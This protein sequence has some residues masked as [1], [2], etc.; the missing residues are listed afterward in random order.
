MKEK[1]INFIADRYGWDE[2]EMLSVESFEELGLDSLSLYSLVTDTEDEFNVKFDT[3]DLTLIDSP[4]KF[5]EYVI[6]CIENADN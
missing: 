2:N 6:G 4:K 3:N 5:I 1:L